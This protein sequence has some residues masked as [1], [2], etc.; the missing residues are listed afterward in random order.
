M[1][2]LPGSGSAS[3]RKR[4]RPYRQKPFEKKPRSEGGD[5]LLDWLNNLKPGWSAGLGGGGGGDGDDSYSE[6]QIDPEK[7]QTVVHLL[8]EWKYYDSNKDVTAVVAS[9]SWTG[10]QMDPATLNTL[11]CPAVGNNVNERIGKSCRVMHI[12]INGRLV[13]VKKTGETAP[14]LA[15]ITRI[16]LYLDKSTAKAQVDGT[17]VMSTAQLAANGCHAFQLLA[18]FKRFQILREKTLVLN[19]PTVV[20]KGAA[21]YEQSGLNVNWFMKYHWKNGLEIRFGA[22]TESVAALVENSLHLIANASDT[23]LVPS[24][25]YCSRVSYKD[26]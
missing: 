18:G 6:I 3:A 9:A 2:G 20:Y 19:S 16:V 11:F 7:I 12:A 14:D 21:S 4:L 10:T 17:V 15:C 24:L 1:Y 13:V 26:S 25:A 5:E 8:S 22:T 23:T